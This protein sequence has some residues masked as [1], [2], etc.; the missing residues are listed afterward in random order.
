MLS[1]FMI[2]VLWFMIDCVRYNHTQ[3]GKTT[4]QIWM[5]KSIITM[6][7]IVFRIMR[8]RVNSLFTPSVQNILSNQANVLNKNNKIKMLPKIVMLPKIDRT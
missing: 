1:I 5:L 2:Y 6:Q 7:E 4:G 3:V 8:G